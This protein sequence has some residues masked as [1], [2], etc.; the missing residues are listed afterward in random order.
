MN[1]RASIALR[2]AQRFDD[3]RRKWGRDCCFEKQVT[4]LAAKFAWHGNGSIHRCLQVNERL[5]SWR[6]KPVRQGHR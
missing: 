1:D 2:A 3:V 5:A 4:A 6:H